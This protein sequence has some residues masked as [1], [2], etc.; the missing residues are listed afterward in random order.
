MKKISAK[1]IETIVPRPMLYLTHYYLGLD[2]IA[3]LLTPEKDYLKLYSVKKQRWDHYLEFLLVKLVKKKFNTCIDYDSDSDSY[4][5]G[6]CQNTHY[7]V[8]VEFI[9]N[10]H[11]EK[12][13]NYPQYP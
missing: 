6:T 13:I 9:Y 3:R 10:T 2:F 4:F 1:A 5:Q 11:T 12:K 8:Y 7:Y